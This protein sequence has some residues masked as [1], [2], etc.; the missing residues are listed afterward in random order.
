[1]TSD[2]ILF[3]EISTIA[4]RYRDHS[5]SPVQVTELALARIEALN[6]MH[7]SYTHLEVY[8]RQPPISAP[9]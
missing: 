4:A 5:L 6:P 8:K 3:A 9:A 2:D 1:M 7:V